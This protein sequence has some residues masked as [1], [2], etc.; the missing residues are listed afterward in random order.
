MK[1]CSFQL[2]KLC[3]IDSLRAGAACPAGALRR[4]AG[5]PASLY[6]SAYDVTLRFCRLAERAYQAELC[7]WDAT[8]IRPAW[9][10]QHRGLLAGQSLMLDLQRMDFAYMERYEPEA[11][12]KPSVALSEL[13]PVA[14]GG[15]SGGD[16]RCSASARRR[17]TKRCST[18]TPGASRR[19]G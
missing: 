8:F 10:V 7:D 3:P 1:V 18:S 13:D 11:E 2:S 5:V 16:V 4:A 14:L 19:F 6:D 9:D 12:G 15:S 17:S